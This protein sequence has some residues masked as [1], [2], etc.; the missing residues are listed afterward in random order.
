MNISYSHKPYA[1]ENVKNHSLAIVT[2]VINADLY[3][4][5]VNNFLACDYPTFWFQGTYKQYGL[6]FLVELFRNYSLKKFKYLLLLDEDNI[7]LNPVELNNIIDS[8]IEKDISIAGVRDGGEISHRNASPIMVNTFFCFL[9][10]EKL[11]KDFNKDKIFE[12]RGFESEDFKNWEQITNFTGSK[13]Y[14]LSLFGEPY[15]SFFLYFRRL[16]HTFYYLKA[17]DYEE[18]LISTKVLSENDEVVAIHTWYARKFG[19]DPEHTKRISSIINKFANFSKNKELLDNK[20][21]KIHHDGK[22]HTAILFFL[23]ILKFQWYR[24]K[25]RSFF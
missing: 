20:A 14:D 18:D 22:I 6:N 4:L 23:T 16:G 1:K 3:A 9:N 5:T 15:Y 24:I 19:V 13:S 17:S 21:I 12:I 8:L 2:S 11:R 10:M 25:S 7:L